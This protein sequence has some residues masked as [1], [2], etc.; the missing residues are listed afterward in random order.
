MM[1]VTIAN[2]NLAYMHGRNVITAT[3]YD[4][5]RKPLLTAALPTLLQRIK[6]EGHTLM[7]PMDVLEQ[8]V[9]T[10]GAGA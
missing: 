6:A 7:N 9:M 8:V 1:N 4:L 2:Y 5:E 10:F 3:I